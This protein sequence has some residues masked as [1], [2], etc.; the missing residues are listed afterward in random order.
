M[1]ADLRTSC[2]GIL[3]GTTLLASTPTIAGQINVPTTVDP[4]QSVK[5][6]LT[7]PAPGS[8]LELWGPVTNTSAGGVLA[9][10]PLDGN[11]AEVVVDQK[12]GSYQLRQVDTDGQIIAKALIDVAAAAVT[13]KVPDNAVAG[14]EMDITWQGPSH[15]GAVLAV[16]DSA[17]NAPIINHPIDA[18]TGTATL[19]APSKTGNYRV[20]YQVGGTTLTEMPLEVVAGGGWLR[21]PLNVTV[22]Q[23]FE[24]AWLGDLDKTRTVRI[25]TEDEKEFYAQITMSGENKGPGEATITAPETPGRYLI[26]VIDSETGTTVTNLPLVVDPA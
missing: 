5:V 18:N 2:F 14:G 8:R 19:Q 26:Q 4:G 20:E 9:Q 24:V 23:E 16:I 11:I 21:S 12:S 3:L 7:E 13:L 25:V 17:T 10:W 22:N 1:T 6:E 15:D